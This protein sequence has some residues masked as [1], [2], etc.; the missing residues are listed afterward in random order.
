MVS[1]KIF[2]LFFLL[3]DPKMAARQ[4]NAI[5]QAAEQQLAMYKVQIL[6][7]FLGFASQIKVT[8]CHSPSRKKG[9]KFTYLC[10]S[11]PLDWNTAGGRNLAPIDIENITFFHKLSCVAISVCMMFS[12]SVCM[13]FSISVCM[14]FSIRVAI[15][16]QNCFF[17][18]VFLP[19]RETGYQQN[20]DVFESC[21]C[22]TLWGSKP[23]IQNWID[24]FIPYGNNGSRSTRWHIGGCA[25]T[26]GTVDQAARAECKPQ[27][28][29]FWCV[30]TAGGK[31]LFHLFLLRVKAV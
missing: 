23:T 2:R 22:P 7:V 30:K 8:H 26:D 29:F 25:G 14:M 4:K 20:G 10:E 28:H 9:W 15:L 6:V 21:P 31:G 24:K 12:I 17:F 5:K 27:D 16:P 19:F 11:F 18:S 13:M 3:P 1:F